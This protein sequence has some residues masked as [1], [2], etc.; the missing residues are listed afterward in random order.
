MQ[1]K[2]ILI[3]SP[4][5]NQIFNLTRLTT[6]DGSCITRYHTSQE[7]PMELLASVNFDMPRRWKK[8]PYRGLGKPGFEA[9]KYHD[10]AENGR[11]VFF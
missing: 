9:R 6:L 4:L 8:T 1:K 3:S 7:I 5:T 2:K 10:F 11:C